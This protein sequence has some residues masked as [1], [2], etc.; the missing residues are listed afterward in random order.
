MNIL[1]QDL[2]NYIFELINLRSKIYFSSSCQYYRNFTNNSLTNS[3]NKFESEYIIFLTFVKILD[4]KPLIL[5]CYDGDINEKH[6]NHEDKNYIC[7]YLS[8]FGHLKQLKW[9]REN[10]CKWD[11]WT[12]FN[13]SKRGHLEILKYAKDNG[14]HCPSNICYDAARYG[15]FEILKWAIEI[16]LDM[17]KC[18]CTGASENGHLEILKWAREH[19]CSWRKNECISV[20][21]K[22]K[23]LDVVKWIEESNHR[24][25]KDHPWL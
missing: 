14:C 18:V 17:D 23:H 11:M 9:A 13:A 16:G 19:G 24:C 21:S 1:P 7:S 3:I 12:C 4:N 6:L 2:I 5:S 22:N 15:H 8:Y 25:E 10:D 20:A